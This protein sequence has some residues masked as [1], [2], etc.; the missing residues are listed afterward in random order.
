MS[1]SIWI[2]SFVRLSKRLSWFDLSFLMLSFLVQVK[3]KKE[4]SESSRTMHKTQKKRAARNIIA[5]IGLSLTTLPKL[6]WAW[7]IL[8]C[9]ERKLSICFGTEEDQGD[10]KWDLHKIVFELSLRVNCK[11]AFSV[12][13]PFLVWLRLTSL[14]LLV[15]RETIGERYPIPHT[16][17]PN[18]FA[19]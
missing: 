5:I 14:V 6:R 17:R 13:C 12:F 9:L 7:V 10:R 19:K 11:M 18:V 15:L 8:F 1:S 4:G 3:P 2:C 16:D